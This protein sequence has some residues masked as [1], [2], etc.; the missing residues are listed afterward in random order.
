MSDVDV[1][2]TLFLQLYHSPSHFHAVCCFLH[3]FFNL[4]AILKR[5]SEY[6]TKDKANIILYVSGAIS[7]E[8]QTTSG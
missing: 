2:V 7:S 6:V 3:N 5:K 1:F 8:Q 4:A